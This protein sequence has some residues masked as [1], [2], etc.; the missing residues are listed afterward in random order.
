MDEYINKEPQKF[1]IAQEY[2]SFSKVWCDIRSKWFDLH[3]LT[4]AAFKLY[5]DSNA[6]ALDCGTAKSMPFNP[7]MVLR[8]AADELGYD[9]DPSTGIWS[10]REFLSSDVAK[11]ISLQELADL[12]DGT[13]TK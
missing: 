12:M 1:T 4:R 11:C 9:R 5:Y 7:E 2:E 13:R 3:P 6:Q 10:K 8:E